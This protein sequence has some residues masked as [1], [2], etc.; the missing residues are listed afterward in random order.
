M[1]QRIQSVFLALSV[2]GNSIFLFL[3]M[4]R[5]AV[6]DP[7]IWVSWVVFGTVILAAGVAG[8]SIFQYENRKKQISVVKWAMLFQIAA[9][10]SVLAIFLTMG[11]IS[12]AM[13][14]EAASIAL[15]GLGLIFQ[16][17]ATVFIAKDEAL[18]RSMDRIR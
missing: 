1:I 14:P 7:A 15:L 6:A 18:V 17:L 9:L 10:A 4:V 5:H 16:Y 13:L 11:R 8:F 3:P 12:S 2:L